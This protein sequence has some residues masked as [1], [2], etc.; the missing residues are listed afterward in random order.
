[1]SSPDTA[2]QSARSTSLL[3]PEV[4]QPSFRRSTL[5]SAVLGS[6]LA[7][8]ATGLAQAQNANPDQSSAGQAQ[9]A[10]GTQSVAQ[11]NVTT[12]APVEVTGQAPYQVREA[13][14]VRMTAPL[15]D[16][17][18][19]VLV[20]PEQLMQDRGVSTL[21]EVLRTTPGITMGAGEGGTPVGDRPF[22]RGYDA[23]SD[24][25]IDGVRDF[26]R[27]YRES[28]NLE[29][30]EIVKG[31][32]SAYG[33][34]G[35]T[36]GTINMQTKAPRNYDFAAVTVGG[37]NASQWS[38]TAD[39]NHVVSDHVAVRLNAMRKGGYTPGR[40][41]VKVNRFGVAPSL[42][43]GLGLP[44]R[45]TLSYLETHNKDTPDFG[46]PFN[47]PAHPEIIRPVG[48]IDRHNFYGRRH[49]DFRDSWSKQ[50][51][52]LL[53]HDLTDALSLRNI[54]RYSRTV[55]AY[56]SGRPSF[57]GL[58]NPPT[59]P[60][61][62]S[63]CAPGALGVCDPADPG[64][65]YINGSRARWRGS[66][67]II[68]QTD[69]TGTF[70]TGAFEHSFATGIEV[71]RD[72]LFNKAMTVTGI[73]N[74]ARESLHNPQ[75]SL[76]YPNASI[77]YGHRTGANDIKTRSIYVFDTMKI[78]EQFQVNGGVRVED[79]EVTNYIITRRDKFANW[80]LGTV[81]KPAAN[82]SVYLT[83]S[84]SSNPAGEDAGQGGG[85]FGS[86]SNATIRDLAPEKTRN[87]ELGTKWDVFGERLS[88]MG[89]IFEIRKTDARSTDPDGTVRLNGN[90]RSRGV[91]L[92]V[93]GAI[94]SK[95][96][97]WAGYTYIDAKN[98]KYVSGT[99]DF[100]GNRL[101]FTP[102][103][104]ASLWTTYKVLPALT[105]GGGV[106]HMGWRYADDNNRLELPGYTT[107]DM[108]VRYDITNSLSL[109]LNGN[110]L[111][112]TEQYDA[113][114][115]GTFYSVGSGR[116]LML[117]ASYRYE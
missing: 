22:L 10:P 52:L 40:D 81:Y 45:M 88:V 34:R 72:R 24:L 92:G 73:G 49:V 16:T 23:G 25:T 115:I 5:A 99:S 47:S 113:S 106:T 11:D 44:T 116:S 109:Q 114:H 85:A 117:T 31:P 51:T 67:T 2:T 70:K 64:A 18:R 102:K 56:L 87:I 29:A 66:Q 1:M 15:R 68:N 33:G 80:Q 53:E 83:Y 112:D 76:H 103:H 58:P 90:N 48:N 42:A 60:P 7:V 50:S 93:S 17:P 89:S 95:W 46:M 54:T 32:S 39:V 43:L 86:A 79:F 74:N 91:E 26:A 111:S 9:S 27:G 110:N 20:V 69:L 98:I 108:M 38:G 41:F 6:A 19:T 14:S 30:V 100:S 97:M 3:S 12:L 55:N 107:W 94:T 8:G 104:A 65:E 61:N 4:F 75:N 35:G 37:G 57:P 63:Q 21:A 36:G 77:T 13:S 78:S 82:G 96:D 105:V 28:F 71:S 84:T 59:N 62:A 101:K